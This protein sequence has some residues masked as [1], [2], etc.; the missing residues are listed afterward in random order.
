MNR[1]VF[2]EGGGFRVTETLLRTP[3]KTYALERVEYVSVQ[4]PLVL[5]V[6]LPAAG[7]IGFTFGFWRYLHLSEAVT[8]VAVSACAI[9]ASLAFGV[10]RVH[11]LALRDDEVAMSFGPVARLRSVRAAVERAMIWRQGGDA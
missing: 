8:L 4:R 9:A 10:L 5:F 7:L 11:S 1:P 3:R 2:Y 6:G